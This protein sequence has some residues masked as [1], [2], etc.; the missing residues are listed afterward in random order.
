MIVGVADVS[1]DLGFGLFYLA[2]VVPYL[3]Y[4]PSARTCPG[5]L[6]VCLFK[7]Q[8]LSPQILRPPSFGF[9]STFVCQRVH[10]LD[11]FCSV[12]HQG[13]LVPDDLLHSPGFRRDMW[14][15]GIR[16]ARSMGKHPC[17]YGVV[18]YAGRRD[19]LD[20]ERIGS[21]SGI[22]AD[23]NASAVF[24]SGTC[25][26][27]LPCIGRMWPLRMRQTLTARDVFIVHDSSRIVP[28]WLI[29]HVTHLLFL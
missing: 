7:I 12:L 28:S 10:K 8:G 17:V 21:I 16:S 24:I 14:Q 11:H 6:H 22:P 3:R 18:F 23:S 13:Y 9:M 20:L 1:L 5:I 2:V 29:T 4:E 27:A 25:G 26:F 19:C 15:L